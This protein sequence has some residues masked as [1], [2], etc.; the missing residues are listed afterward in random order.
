[1]HRIVEPLP[2]LFRRVVLL[3]AMAIA[4]PALAEAQTPPTNQIAFARDAVQPVV[5]SILTVRE[6]FR[7]G[8]PVL[9]VASGSGTVVTAQGHIATNA[10]VT[11]NGKSFRIV[12]ADGRE[13]PA[14]LVGVDTLS[15]LAVLQAMPGKPEVFAHAAFAE[16]LDLLAGDTVLAMGAPWGLSNSV[17]A[18]VVN[19][20]RRLLVSLFDDEA[21]YEDRLGDDQ[22]TGRYYA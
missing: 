6:D 16:T 11:E 22:P 5:V 7:Q 9:S 18:G 4:T 13:L 19:N 15:D 1:M 10:H 12:F 20:P 3:A 14:K 2:E 8:A 21:D 17:S